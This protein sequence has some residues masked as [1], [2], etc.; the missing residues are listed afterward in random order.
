[1]I[2]YVGKPS[3]DRWVSRIVIVTLDEFKKTAVV[4]SDQGQEKAFPFTLV[5]A[6]Q[7]VADKL[8]MELV[9]V[10]S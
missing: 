1:M 9:K 4:F 2:Y 10:Q 7:K 6:A 3:E 8:N 5:D